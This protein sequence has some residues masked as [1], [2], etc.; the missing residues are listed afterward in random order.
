MMRMTTGGFLSAFR[1]WM[2]EGLIP[3]SACVS[4]DSARPKNK[5]LRVSFASARP[6]NAPLRVSCAPA[7]SKTHRSVSASSHHVRN[8]QR[9]V[10]ARNERFQ[11]LDVG[12]DPVQRLVR[13]L[14]LAIFGFSVWDSSLG[15]ESHIQGLRL[16]VWTDSASRSEKAWLREGLHGRVYGLW[17][18]V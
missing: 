1:F 7:R 13:A 17:F 16:S 10:S 18:M 2:S 4:F 9:S 11:V 3:F 8:A 12:L 5:T 14:R 15:C 6:K